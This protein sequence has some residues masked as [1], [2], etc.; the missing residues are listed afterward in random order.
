MN[1]T[2]ISWG[3]LIGA[4]S[5]SVL[6]SSGLWALLLKKLDRKDNKTRL[7]LGLA[8]DRIV[9]IGK[10]YIQRGW[11]SYDEYEDFMN[12]LYVPY[13]EFGGNGLAERIKKEVGELPVKPAGTV[14]L[15]KEKF[16]EQ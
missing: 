4:I 13:S 6:A 12:Y 8:H 5:A 11:I 16:S 1:V 15:E 2:V 14:F 7:L 10:A 3:E 9:H